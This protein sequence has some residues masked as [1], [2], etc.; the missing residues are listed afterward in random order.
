V[1]DERLE[2]QIS[3]YA[4]GTLPAGDVAALEAV[5]ASN[6]EARALLAEYQSLDGSLKRE[7]PLPA[8]NWDRLAAHLSGAVAAEDERQAARA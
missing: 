7:L 2:F 3:Q 6:A 5:L 1:I 8:M 4:D